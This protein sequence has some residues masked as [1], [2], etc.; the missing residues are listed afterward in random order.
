M[1]RDKKYFLEIYIGIIVFIVLMGWLV[2][3]LVSMVILVVILGISIV[4]FKDLK[5]S[6]PIILY[7]IFSI[8]NGFDTDEIPIFYIVIIICFVVLLIGFNLKAGFDFKNMGSLIGLLGL[9]ISNLIPIFWTKLDNPIYYS[10]Y[11]I[12]FGY[13]LLYIMLNNGIKSNSKDVLCIS[14][15]YLGVILAFEC[16]FKI[17]ALKDT[18][19]NIFDL[20]YY[21]GWG[22][23]NE[24]GIL[25]CMGLPFNFYLLGKM[26]KDW[27]YQLFKIIIVIVGMFLSMSRGTYIFGIIE[28]MILSVS[29]LFYSHNKDLYKKIFTGIIVVSCLLALMSLPFIE[30]VILRVFKDGFTSNGRI[31]IWNIGINKWKE[32]IMFGPGICSVMMVLNT[33]LG[34]QEVPLVFHCTIIEVLVVGGVLGLVFFSVHMYQKYKALFKM[35]RL[36]LTTSLIGYVIVDIYGLIDN[37]YYMYYYMI[38]LVVI[39]ASIDKNLNNSSV[40]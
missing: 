24:A 1:L 40:M 32:N 18:V 6:I 28:F 11:F 23:C 13:L 30:D 17:I 20:S 35:D 22:V 36:F 16:I 39:M 37:T 33:A 7:I 3:T 12:G 5:Y 14:M 38:V 8:S 31:N 25:M 27:I 9:A 15:S 2:N 34:Y 19:N 29:L 10:F 4:I 26:N 21:L